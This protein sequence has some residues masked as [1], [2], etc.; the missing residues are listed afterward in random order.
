MENGFPILWFLDKKT[1]FHIYIVF[2][3]AN[4]DNYRSYS[5]M[6]SLPK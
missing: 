3:T 6:T 2:M 5:K 1:D 4:L